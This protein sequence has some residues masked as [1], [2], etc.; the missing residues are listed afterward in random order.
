MSKRQFVNKFCTNTINQKSKSNLFQFELNLSQ[1]NLSQ[2]K[3][4]YSNLFQFEPNFVEISSINNQDNNQV[5]TSKR[6]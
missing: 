1:T 5:N 2:F 4:N 6:V 3:S